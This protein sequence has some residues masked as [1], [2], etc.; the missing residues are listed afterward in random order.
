MSKKMT[1]RNMQHGDYTLL[2]PDYARHRPAYS[3]TVLKAIIGLIGKD[4]RKIHAVDVGAGTGI[5]TRMV[6]RQGCGVTAI[7]PNDEMRKFGIAHDEASTIRWLKGKAEETG[8]PRNCC[9]LVTMASSFHWTKFDKA[10]KEF[11][12]ILKAGGWFAALWNTRSLE[13]NPLLVEIENKLKTIVPDLKRVSSGKSEFCATLR[14]RL[15]QCGRFKDVLYIEGRHSERMTPARYIGIWR[16]VNDV[17]VQ[18]GRVRFEEFMDYLRERLH[19]V[20]YIDAVYLTRAW[21]AQVN[22]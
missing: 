20:K 17:Y 11:N 5:W 16:S 9:D 12:R 21:I 4:A 22:K 1:M 7:E 14:E 6:S 3:D 8:L 13:N 18:A 10:A 15:Y 19:T 2:A